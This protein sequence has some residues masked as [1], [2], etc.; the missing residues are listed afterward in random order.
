MT[1]RATRRKTDR[2]E[3]VYEV[4]DI[5]RIVITLADEI[6]ALLTDIP[7]K[8]DPAQPE[9]LQ[10]EELDQEKVTSMVK[11]AETGTAADNGE[12][13]TTTEPIPEE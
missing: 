4:K 8:R 5:P 7:D 12:E 9:T 6:E 11:G 3:P 2:E 13:G 10:K 1:I